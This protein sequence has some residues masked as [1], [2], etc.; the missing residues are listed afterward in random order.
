MKTTKLRLSP[1][2]CFGAWGF[3]CF[4]RGFF[5]CF[6]VFFCLVFG[7]LVLVSFGFGFS[8]DWLVG[9]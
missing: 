1:F 8:F 2:C 4:L 3:F 9:F 6:G 5:V 7:W